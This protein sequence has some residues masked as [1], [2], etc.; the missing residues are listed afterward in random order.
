MN[1]S[2]FHDK[3]IHEISYH[4]FR[5]M[6]N[7]LNSDKWFKKAN[8]YRIT[9]KIGRG[10]VLTKSLTLT[11]NSCFDSNSEKINKKLTFGQM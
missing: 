3:K 6:E 11:T 2:L 8:K 9:M 10:H 1:I 4:F 5:E 7:Y